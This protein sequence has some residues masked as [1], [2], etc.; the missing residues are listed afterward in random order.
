MSTIVSVSND[1][2]MV[3]AEVT[4]FR[5]NYKVST[6]NSDRRMFLDV[7][8]Y[9][10]IVEVHITDD[11][12][13]QLVVKCEEFAYLHKFVEKAVVEQLNLSEKHLPLV[14]E[15]VGTACCWLIFNDEAANDD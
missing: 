15:A 5:T 12:T 9:L 3:T 4:D 13:Y 6:L 8:F 1:H 2:V 10:L 14:L 11:T 7:D